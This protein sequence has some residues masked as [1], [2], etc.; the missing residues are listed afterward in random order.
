MTVIFFSDF[1]RGWTSYLLFLPLDKIAFISFTSHASLMQLRVCHQLSQCFA[2]R[3]SASAAICLLTLHDNR[4]LHWQSF[5]CKKWKNF[6]LRQHKTK[7]GIKCWRHKQ[8]SLSIFFFSISKKRK[9][10]K[11][12]AIDWK[13]RR[14]AKIYTENMP[15]QQRQSWMKRKKG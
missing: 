1:G 2:D 7:G 15:G 13:N 8:K 4:S 11:V 5:N 3:R 14:Q 12:M 6:L 9:S 10:E